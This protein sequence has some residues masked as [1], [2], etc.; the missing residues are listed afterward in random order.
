MRLLVLSFFLCSLSLARPQ[1]VCSIGTLFQ[2]SAGG[3]VYMLEVDEKRIERGTRFEMTKLALKMK[4]LGMC[5]KIEGLP[6]C[7]IIHIGRTSVQAPFSSTYRLM[8]GQQELDRAFLPDL[9]DRAT[10]WGCREL[11]T[12]EGF[13]EIPNVSK[14]SWEP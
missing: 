2:R 11:G 12:I 13:K 10:A 3:R 5:E 6:N 14:S 4:S 7:S 8:D 9:L 1:H